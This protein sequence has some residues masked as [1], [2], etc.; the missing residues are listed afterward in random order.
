ME[1]ENT[2][3]DDDEIWLEYAQQCER[4]GEPSICLLLKTS[5]SHNQLTPEGKME[6]NVHQVPGIENNQNIFNVPG[7]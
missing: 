4:H 7:V 5:N 2:E 1:E 6:L 3:I